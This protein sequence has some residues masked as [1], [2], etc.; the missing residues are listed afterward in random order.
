MI[1]FQNI[2]EI[3]QSEYQGRTREA[4]ATQNGSQQSL[5]TQES[6]L[7]GVVRN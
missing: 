3:N 7:E 1:I 6:V 4:L 2:G 5:A